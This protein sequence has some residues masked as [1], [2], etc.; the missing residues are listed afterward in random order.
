M[1]HQTLWSQNQDFAFETKEY[2]VSKK[3]K[4]EESLAL[5]EVQAHGVSLKELEGYQIVKVILLNGMTNP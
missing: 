5:Q 3:L 2:G 4:T 1:E